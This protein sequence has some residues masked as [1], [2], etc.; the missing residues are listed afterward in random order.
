MV[1]RAG[2]GP[3]CGRSRKPCAARAWWPRWP[4]SSGSIL[5]ASRRLQLAAEGHGV[6]ALLLRP[7]LAR[8]PG[9]ASAAA[10]RWR[11]TALPG[12]GA[13]RALGPPALAGR[14]FSLPRRPHPASGRSSWR[15][16]GWHGSRILSLWLPTLATDRLLR[17][18]APA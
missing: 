7:P 4:R 8:A 18:A 11:I 9:A 3:P 13:G 12:A 6:T 10:T 14:N 5:T 1:A 15:E 17:R 2:A 16:E